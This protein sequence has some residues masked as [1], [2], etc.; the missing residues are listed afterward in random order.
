MSR[1][2]GL[3]CRLSGL[4]HAGIGRYI[5]N[6]GKRLPYMAR[7]VHWVYFVFSEDQA[8]ELFP[9]D[10][11]K[12]VSIILTPIKHYSLAEQTRL[13]PLFVKANLDLLHVPH[14]NVP[15][16]YSKPFLITIHDLLWHHH[17]GQEVTTLKGWK[18]WFKY[19]G[20]RLVVRAAVSRAR[21]VF[22]PTHTIKKTF[23]SFFPK[24][25]EKTSVTYEGVDEALLN[26]VTN[27]AN[28]PS[29][30]KH[31]KNQLLYVGS[32]Y[33]H[34][35]IA[36]VLEALRKNSSLKLVLVGSRS[37]FQDKVRDQ[38]R[39]FNLNDQVEFAGFVP[40]DVLKELYRDS[41]ALIQPSLSEGFGLTGLEAL[42]SGGRVV[43]SDT[44]IFHEV[45]EDLAVFFDP[46][47]AEDLL[48]KVA[49]IQEKLSQ[50]HNGTD[51]N[52]QKTS[53]LL[54]KYSWDR[55]AQQTLNQYKKTLSSV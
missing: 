22:V 6:L 42:A 13:G 23:G 28:K 18:Y 14:F 9:D 5:L 54:Q 4:Q 7:D 31:N 38:V 27:L 2:I 3:D 32:L 24:A 41:L 1:T 52:A 20:Y 36:V 46:H 12:N 49:K 34:K 16:N 55:M 48:D 44:P 21:H 33:P 11:P 8:L 10:K 19:F 45:Y 43:A 39:E 25:V 51:N 50:K 47:S 37:V 17:R 15:L 53:N 40:D 29:P 30:S 26:S 35:N